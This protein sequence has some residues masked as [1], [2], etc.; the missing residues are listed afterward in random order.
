M[1]LG[2]YVINLEQDKNKW[3]QMKKNFVDTDIVLNRYNAIYGQNKK[4]ID[5]KNI[6]NFCWNLCP[7]AVL[8]CGL[9]HLT[10]MQKINKENKYSYAL[11][12]EDDAIPLYKDLKKKIVNIIKNVEDKDKDWDI[13]K[14]YC[15]GLCDYKKNT[16]KIPKFFHGATVAYLVSKKGITKISN[17]KLV[18]HMDIQYAFSKLK[19][20]KSIKPLFETSIEKSR[21]SEKNTLI[22]KIFNFKISENTLPTYYYLEQKIIKLPIINY[23]LTLYEIIILFILLKIFT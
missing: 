10:L 9:S 15:Q 1:N 19:I 14:L 11:I 22:K 3:K 4:S 5:K 6:T 17:M 16:I 12:L 13:I 23:E 8:G 7:D 20:Y 18:Y 21:T 2:T